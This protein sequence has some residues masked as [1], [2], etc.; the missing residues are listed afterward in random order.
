MTDEHFEQQLLLCINKLTVLWHELHDFDC[1]C[2]REIDDSVFAFT[3]NQRTV[4][5]QLK[6]TFEYFWVVFTLSI[7]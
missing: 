7:L 3:C 6:S 2:S 5:N 1:G 4:Y